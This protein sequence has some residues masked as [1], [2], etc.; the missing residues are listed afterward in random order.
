MIRA[1]EFD[2]TARM[3]IE[4]RIKYMYRRMEKEINPYYDY[5]ERGLLHQSLGNDTE[6]LNDFNKV[7]E[8]EYGDDDS[9]RIGSYSHLAEKYLTRADHYFF[10]MQKYEEAIKDYSEL[11]E[12]YKEYLNFYDYEA[13]YEESMGLNQKKYRHISFPPGDFLKVTDHIDVLYNL[14]QDIKH[15]PENSDM[16]MNR[17]IVY[18]RTLEYALAISDFEKAIDLK[19]P[20]SG[21]IKRLLWICCC[22]RINKLFPK[23]NFRESYS[24]HDS[25]KHEEAI[26]FYTKAINLEPNYRELYYERAHSYFKLNDFDNVFQ[27]FTKVINLFPHYELYM[28]FASSCEDMGRKDE[29]EK[30]YD[31]AIELFPEN[32]KLYRVRCEFYIRSKDDEKALE[33]FETYLKKELIFNYGFYIRSK[34]DEK[35]LENSFHSKMK[36]LKNM[37]LFYDLADK[38]SYDHSWF[39]KLFYDKFERAFYNIIVDHYSKIPEAYMH[40]GMYF[41]EINKYNEA[42]ND[43]KKSIELGLEDDSLIYFLRGICYDKISEKDKSHKDFDRAGLRF[44]DTF[45]DER[46]YSNNSFFRKLDY[47]SFLIYV[48]ENSSIYEMLIVF[49]LFIQGL[50]DGSCGMGYI[51]DLAS[52]LDNYSGS[53]STD[54]IFNEHID[55]QDYIKK[56][57]DDIEYYKNK[58]NEALNGMF[59]SYYPN[60]GHSSSTTDRIFNECLDAQSRI[61]MCK[62]RIDRLYEAFNEIFNDIFPAHYPNYETSLEYVFNRDGKDAFLFFTKLSFLKF[63]FPNVWK[64]EENFSTL[65]V[66]IYSKKEP[67]KKLEPNRPRFQNENG[68]NFD[69]SMDDNDRISFLSMLSYLDAQ[70]IGLM[71]KSRVKIEHEQ[72][73]AQARID[74]RN[75]IIA[76]LSHSIKN[77]ISTVIDPL[78]N[79]KR[80]T[81][82]KPQVI[83]NA[84]RGANLVRE[85]VNA[86]NLSFSGSVE[87]FYCDARNIGRDSVNL[88]SVFVESL[89][90][91]IGNMFDD[92]YFPDFQVEY[93]ASEDVLE[94]AESQWTQISQSKDLQKIRDF[95]KE[96]FFE[97]DF[98]FETT[99]DYVMGNDKGSAIKLMILFQEVIFNAVKYSAFVSMEER[100]LRIQFR[101]TPEQIIVRIE[102]PYNEKINVSTSGIGHVI[103]ENFCKLMETEPVVN[104]ENCIYAVEIRFANFWKEESE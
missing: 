104:K 17:G 53:K 19:S 42:I 71:E 56:C 90:Y 95:L 91:S 16:F 87:D 48:T 21:F 1:I 22:E 85:I 49:N 14:N 54:R 15:H 12:F 65:S 63:I 81:S 39:K 62:H 31:K 10:R 72:E 100:L 26:K 30:I 103:V 35:A 78:E 80:E 93:F 20:H 102:N 33:N 37:I 47:S 79:L 27:D 101:D 11:I 23:K 86:M 28:D 61:K 3:G 43:F 98:S 66:G 76:D 88:Q 51:S 18:F 55:A 64:A 4:E 2:E 68:R 92:K 60:Y 69:R 82:V 38:K 25:K 97:T 83:D 41:M 75:K 8:L 52:L 89:I 36:N 32:R 74:E 45:D 70:Q 58:I 67:D 57:K 5:E 7:I 77:L 99:T 73:I 6:A 84:L 34:D 29:A 24:T 59:P 40:R 96:Y 9:S 50:L 44:F 13:K 46:T 94:K